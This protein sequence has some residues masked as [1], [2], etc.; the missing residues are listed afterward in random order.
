[1]AIELESTIKY[2]DWIP[3]RSP[4]LNWYAQEIRSGVPFSL[5][6]YGEG[7][8]RVIVPAMHVKKQ[9]VYSEWHAEKAQDKLRLTLINCHTSDRYYPAI[10]HQRGAARGGRMTK[11][12][13]WMKHNNLDWIKWHDGRLWRRATER[14]RVSIMVKAIRDQKLPLVVVGPKRIEQRMKGKFDVARF[15]PIHPTHAY[16]DRGK[17]VKSV[18]RFDKP[19]LISF[20]AGGT[21]NILIHTLFPFIGEESYLIDFG[22]LWE[23]LSGHRTRPYHKSLSPSRVRKNGEGK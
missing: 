10:W 22:A 17:I 8:W 19:A 21:A 6:R 18:L 11:I 4:G 16:N 5:S 20:S 12:K 13:S 14:D 2:R 9:R 15:I 3:V 1:M 7:E 23:G